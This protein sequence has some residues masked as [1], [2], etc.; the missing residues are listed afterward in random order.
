MT[1]PSNHEF[2]DQ[3]EAS[4]EKSY[5]CSTCGNM[6]PITQAHCE[7]CGHDC[8]TDTCRIIGASNVGF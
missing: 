6:Y 3:A 5:K 2:R 4:T 1:N 7:V 8:T